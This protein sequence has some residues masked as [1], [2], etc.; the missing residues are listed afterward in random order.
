MYRFLGEYRGNEMPDVEDGGDRITMPESALV[1]LTT[2]YP[3]GLPNAFKLTNKK[4]GGSL[5]CGVLNWQAEEGHIQIPNWM[6]EKL[7]L[8]EGGMLKVESATLDLGTYAR[9]KDQSDQDPAFL[10]LTNPHA[11][12]EAKLKHFACLSKGDV[13]AFNYINKVYK[14]KVE[15]TR[16]NDAV[17]IVNCDLKYDLLPPEGYE[18]QVQQ[19]RE[20]EP[21]LDIAQ[22]LP[23]RKSFVAF[24]GSGNKLNG[25]KIRTNSEHEIQSEQLAE[26]T[27]G[28]PDYDFQVANLN[29]LRNS[30]PIPDDKAQPREDDQPEPDISQ[31]LEEEKEN[32]KDFQPFQ[33][34]GQS[35]RQAKNKK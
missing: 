2:Q 33:G 35:L 21:K 29:F 34:A 4:N 3:E 14:F 5:H 8:D 12:L 26:V 1:R 6:F 30:K 31:P 32:G 20:D 11:I 7:Q 25:K 18:A 24:P 17:S 13:I 19:P 23:E 28:I 9:F 15:E 22:L 10:D 27:R 16:P